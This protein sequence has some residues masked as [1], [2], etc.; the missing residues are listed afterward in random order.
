MSVSEDL[1]QNLQQVLSGNHW[2]GSPVYTI[3]GDVSFEAAFQKPL[4]SVH[5]IAGILLHIIA[6]TEEV[7]DRLNGMDA[8]QPTSGDWPDPGIPDEQKWHNYVN[9]FK[10]V[11]LNLLGTIE[12]LPDENW[13]NLVN[14]TVENDPGTTYEA[15]VRGLIQHHIYHAAQIALLN[16]MIN[17]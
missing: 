9:D 17:G 11:N 1:Q 10:L 13:Y 16:R 2:Y 5:N 3:I 4:G 6:W 14:G 15:L 12:N 8:Q 7:I